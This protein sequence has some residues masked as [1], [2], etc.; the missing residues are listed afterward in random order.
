MRCSICGNYIKK[1]ER[2]KYTIFHTKNGNLRY[3]RWCVDCDE[4]HREAVDL[5]YNRRLKID[6]QYMNEQ[7]MKWGLI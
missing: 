6:E 5:E 2:Y 7:R 4:K 3:F 1:K